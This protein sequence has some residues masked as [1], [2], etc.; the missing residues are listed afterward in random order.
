MFRVLIHH[1]DSGIQELSILIAI[2]KTLRMQL[3]IKSKN[4]NSKDS[5][6]KIFYDQIEDGPPV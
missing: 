6:H 5:K 3:I 1:P 4:S 2:M